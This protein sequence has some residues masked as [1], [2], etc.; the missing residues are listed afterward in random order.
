MWTPKRIVLLVLGFALFS[1]GYFSYSFVLGGIDGLPPLPPELLAKLDPEGRTITPPP[2]VNKV[3]IK[4]GQAFGL[5]C[6]ELK[7]DIKLELS[8]NNMVLAADDFKINDEGRLVLRPFSVAMFGKPK[9][10]GRYPEINTIRADVAILTF[11][12]P[13]PKDV[14]PNNLNGR[15]IVGAELTGNIEVVNNRRTARRDD[16]IELFVRTGPL[17]YEEAKHLIWTYD[18]VHV[19][20]RHIDSP[21]NQVWG[22]GMELELQVEAET[23]HPPTAHNKPHQDTI[24]GVKRITLQANVVMDLFVDGSSGFINHS[25]KNGATKPQPDDKVVGAAPSKDEKDAAKAKEPPEK[26]NLHITTPGRFNYLLFKDYDM[27]HFEVTPGVQPAPGGPKPRD[28]AVVRKNKLGT[29]QLFCQV[30]DLKLTRNENEKKPAAAPPVKPAGSD[31]RDEDQNFSIE[32]VHATADEN[33][34]VTLTSD[35]EKLIVTE[36][37]DLMHEAKTGVTVLKGNPNLRADKDDN[38]LT[39]RQLTIEE[40]KILGSDKTYQKATALGPGKIDLADKKATQANKRPQHALWNDTLI[41][42]KD[43]RT[44]TAKGEM[45]DMLILTGAARFEDDEHAQTLQGDTLKVWLISAG[46]KKVDKT[47]PAQPSNPG[48]P[49]GAKADHVEVIGNVS[50]HSRELNIHD[51]TRLVVWFKDAPPSTLPAVLDGE[52]KVRTTAPPLDQPKGVL[53]PAV[54]GDAPRTLPPGPVT[55]PENPGNNPVVIVT[56]SAPPAAPPTITPAKPGVASKPPP[57]PEEPARPIDLSARSVEAWVL[58]EGETKNTLEKLWS[59]GSV[60]VHQAPAKVGD[61]PVDI[62][63][64]TLNMIYHPDGDLLVVTGNDQDLARLQMDKILILGP[65]VNI[66]QAANKAWVVGAGAMRIDS[67]TTLSGKPLDKSQPLTIQWQKSMLVHGRYAEFNVGI[68]A[69]QDQPTQDSDALDQARMACNTLRVN[70]DRPISLKE[71]N[72]GEQ[73]PKVQTLLCDQNARVEELVYEHGKLVKYERLEAPTISESALQ[74]LDDD[75]RKPGQTDAGNEVRASGPGVFRTVGVG[76]IDPLASPNDPKQKPQPNAKVAPQT[77]AKPPAPKPAPK[78]EDEQLKLTLV[79]FA[80]SM[81]GN[82]QKNFVSFRKNVRVVNMPVDN[83]FMD[84]DIDVTL[85]KLP[86]GAMYLSCQHLE[87]YTREEKGKKYQEMHAYEQAVVQSNEFWGRAAVIH[88]DEAKDQVIFDGDGGKATLY[89]FKR[90]GVP[91]EQIR[92]TKI[93]YNRKT[94]EFTGENLESLQAD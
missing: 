25:D 3:D 14:N 59:E 51:T 77:S 76:G 63:G 13:I 75:Q 19:T 28:V 55:P 64:D 16:D 81:Y 36:V 65:E 46:D 71:G 2:R 94:G 12:R 86:E 72:K 56:P 22:K 80:G 88:F 92:G 52:G 20:D 49:G 69:T 85:A 17:Y 1:A 43:E 62:T 37:N 93:I 5:E 27:A 15:K 8:R 74:F 91:P 73:S 44:L 9:N 41:S 53:P 66:D 40:I 48:Q 45:Q 30:L 78:P 26:S 18:E 10:D 4:L 82:S 70:F 31:Q 34:K 61:Q 11:D 6:R 38:V 21:P 83:P 58:R 57:K 60:H 84:V 90:P 32:S 89:K 54:P 33:S 29:D 87:V 67:T 47:T 24:T 68:Q 50:A 23:P 7:R 79:E 42:T 35:A 39:T